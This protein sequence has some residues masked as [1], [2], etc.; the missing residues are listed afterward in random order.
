MTVIPSREMKE[1]AQAIIK[2]LRTTNLADNVEALAEY[3]ERMAIIRDRRLT[4][5][6]EESKKTRIKR[7]KS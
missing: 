1:A 3:L 7:R 6:K 2:R 5:N 4:R